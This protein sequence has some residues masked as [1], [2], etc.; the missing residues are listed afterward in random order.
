M[1]T[2][3]DGSIG[4]SLVAIVAVVGAAATRLVGS[5]ESTASAAAFRWL[6]PFRR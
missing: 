1:T 2:L 3:P 6:R 4:G 5:D